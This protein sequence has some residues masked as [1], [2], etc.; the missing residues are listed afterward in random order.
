VVTTAP[1]SM[2]TSR[3]RLQSNADESASKCNKTGTTDP[4]D[5]TMDVAIA[6]EEE[7]EAKKGGKKGK[8]AKKTGGKGKN[9][10]LSFF[11][12]ISYLITSIT[13]SRKT[14][15]ERQDEDEVENAK[16]IPAHIKPYVFFILK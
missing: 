8:K 11:I 9:M 7:N 2:S 6:V 15:A 5:G 10:Y 4:E 1:K 12:I 13:S 14:W 3:K 16:G